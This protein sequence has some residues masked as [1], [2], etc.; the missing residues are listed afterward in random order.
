MILRFL[1]QIQDIKIGQSGKK[2]GFAKRF[3]C[4]ESVLWCEAHSSSKEGLLGDLWAPCGLVACRVGLSVYACRKRVAV[5]V[6]LLSSCLSRQ[7]VR[8]CL[9]WTRCG[10]REKKD[11]WICLGSSK[12]GP[13]GGTEDPQ[14]E[15][16]NKCWTLG[17]WRRSHISALSFGLGEGSWS[18]RGRAWGIQRACTGAAASPCNRQGQCCTEPVFHGINKIFPALLMPSSTCA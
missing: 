10:W 18:W 13:V 15:Y 12:I 5:W 9:S 1:N 6:P 11:G 8:R 14:Q 3:L 17:S 4:T 7:E 16:G 2:E